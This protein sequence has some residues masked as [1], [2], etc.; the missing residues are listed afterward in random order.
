MQEREGSAGV[1]DDALSY[2]FVNG[3]GLGWGNGGFYNGGRY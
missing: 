2:V 3:S 1:A